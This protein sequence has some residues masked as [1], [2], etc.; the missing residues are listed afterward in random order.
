[1]NE[2][3]QTTVTTETEG[4]GD[5]PA[6]TETT[7]ET[8]VANEPAEAMP[9]ALADVPPLEW[10]DGGA[11]ESEAASKVPTGDEAGPHAYVIDLGEMG[12]VVVVNSCDELLLDD[13]PETFPDVASAKAWCEKRDAEIFNAN[14]AAAQS[15]VTQT[16]A[17]E[18]P[19][20]EDE[21][22]VG[23]V[24]FVEGIDLQ[25]WH[26]IQDARK[27]ERQAEED[28]A[29]LTIDLKEAKKRHEAAS[30]R[31]G[32]LIDEAEH[33]TLFSR[34]AV[35]PAE[36]ADDAE[37]AATAGNATQ[38]IPDPIP[39]P[40]DDAWKAVTIEALGIT[41]K[42]VLTALHNHIPNPI[43][44]HGELAAWQE[45]KTQY[46]ATDIKGLGDKGR[47]EIEN[48]QANYWIANP[49]KAATTISEATADAHLT[50]PAQTDAKLDTP[51]ASSEPT[52]NTVNPPQS[53][54]SLGLTE[55]MVRAAYYPNLLAKARKGEAIDCPDVV[56]A[57]VDADPNQEWIA[58]PAPAE[59][60][61][62]DY[63]L[64]PLYAD[65]DHVNIA[66]GSGAQA[67]VMITHAGDKRWLGCDEAS[68][69]VTAKGSA[70]RLPPPEAQAEAD[71]VNLTK[72]QRYRGNPNL[73]VSKLAEPATA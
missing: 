35:K 53:L 72:G 70:E 9:G 48:A 27:D 38:N 2:T 5:A 25:A 17:T 22:K 13:Y 49:V 40:E 45:K 24:G 30:S 20:A 59:F 69:A 3:D 67:G 64:V 41:T 57:G 55:E 63:L 4:T 34:Q 19:P 58:L 73:R 32:K 61:G 54:A 66:T 65:R 42:R 50:E 46:W 68:I 56:R 18:Q 52:A 8:P 47:E 31:L 43:T 44:T 21:E 28:V 15:G 6:P 14:R 29:E 16:P 26:N 51:S 23:S 60:K 7:T 1:M 11:V 10:K 62:A 36:K 39:A 37:T 71:V 33:P 12:Q